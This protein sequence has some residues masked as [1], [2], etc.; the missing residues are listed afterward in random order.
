MDHKKKIRMLKMN[1]LFVPSPLLFHLLVVLGQFLHQIHFQHVV[2]S[3]QLQQ[4]FPQIHHEFPFAPGNGLCKR[5]SKNKQDKTKP[6]QFILYLIH[7]VIHSGLCATESGYYTDV[8][9]LLSLILSCYLAMPF[10]SPPILLQ[11]YNFNKLSA[12]M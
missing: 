4:T 7:P 1:Y 8:L 3:L 10:L 9:C 6:H 2:L 12:G 11:K 5:K